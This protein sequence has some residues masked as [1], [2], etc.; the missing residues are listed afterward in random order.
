MTP[1]LDYII[2]AILLSCLLKT[3]G[4]DFFVSM[5]IERFKNFNFPVV[6]VVSTREGN[7]FP[8][9]FSRSVQRPV[10][11]RDLRLRDSFEQVSCS[12]SETVS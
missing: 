11:S 9:D 5:L 2:Y 8:W 7:L 4:V 12:Q 1:D 10:S 6:K 3:V